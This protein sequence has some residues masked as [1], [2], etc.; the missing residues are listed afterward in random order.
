MAARLYKLEIYLRMNTTPEAN[1]DHRL[2]I[3]FHIHRTPKWYFAF[4]TKGLRVKFIL[5]YFTR[6]YLLLEFF[7]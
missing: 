4:I 5:L 1:I 2:R 6:L 7:K 3:Q